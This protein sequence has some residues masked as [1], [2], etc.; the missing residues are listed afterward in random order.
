[1]ALM[2]LKDRTGAKMARALDRSWYNRAGVERVMG[3]CTEKEYLEFLRSCPEFEH[4]LICSD[5][6]LL[7]YWF[8]VEA[9]LPA[10]GNSG[11][12]MLEKR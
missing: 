10:L 6:V 4:M 2:K 9:P 11:W 12:R 1:M 5:I 7:K 8:S 3:F